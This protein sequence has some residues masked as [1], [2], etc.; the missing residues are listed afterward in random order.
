MAR[1]L[2]LVH[3]FGISFNIWKELLP[4]LCPYFTLVMVELPGI[5]ESPMPRPG[6]IIYAQP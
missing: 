2:L 1:P 3:G 4:L 6:R 5:G